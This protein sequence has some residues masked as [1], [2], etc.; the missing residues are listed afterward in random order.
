M[1]LLSHAWHLCIG[2]LLV[3]LTLAL[4]AGFDAETLPYIVSGYRSLTLGAICASTSQCPPGSCCLRRGPG[5]P[6]CHPGAVLGRGCSHLRYRNIYSGFC[7][8]VRGATCHQ[9]RRICE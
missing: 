6:F 9:W 2:L 7:P 4:P 8:C 3:H 1:A 5:G